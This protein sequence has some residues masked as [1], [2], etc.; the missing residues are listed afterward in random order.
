VEQLVAGRLVTTAPEV[1]RRGWAPVELVDRR[2]DDPRTGLFSERFTVVARTVLEA[3]GRVVCVLNRVGRVRL[4]S[5]V[6]CGTLACCTR[7]GGAVSQAEAAGPLVCPRCGDRRPSLCAAC[8]SGRLRSLRIGVTRATEEVTALLG[9]VAVEVS[10]SSDPPPQD[11]PL[12]VGTEA[13][14]HR[15]PA[16][17]LVAFLDV[18]QH[19]LA[20]RF[21]A[22]EETLALVARASRVVGGRRA[23]GR[24]GRI[25]LQTRL[26][27]HPAL[28]AAATADPGPLAQ[29]EDEVRAT[30]GLPP[31]GA[32]ATVAGAA[33]GAFVAEVARVVPAGT[34]EVTPFG[35]DRWLLRADDHHR[36]CDTL[37][38]TARPPGRL[39]VVVDPRD[40]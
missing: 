10:G 21:A 8:D 40:V 24:R 31:H 26:P 2:D 32:L 34:V 20:H 33:A 23:G 15:V 14:L 3:G 36:L 28:V 11:A 38:A 9:T 6:A 30:L 22:A 35:P 12:V 39:R 1:E 37:A 7:C 17:D 25:L 29:A 16:A 4:L 27:A 18:D 13:A 19:L 5:C